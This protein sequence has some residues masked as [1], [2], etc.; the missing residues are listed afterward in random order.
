MSFGCGRST[1]RHSRW[2][3]EA[4]RLD[5]GQQRSAHQKACSAERE[6]KL[7]GQNEAQ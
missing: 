3:E 7:D 1:F 2:L 6:M 5:A 4:R